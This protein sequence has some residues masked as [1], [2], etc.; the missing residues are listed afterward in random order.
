MSDKIRN[1]RN[2]WIDVETEGR[3]IATGPRKN[4]EST[5]I[6]LSVREK[7]K[8]KAILQI[9]CHQEKEDLLVRIWDYEKLD[10]I[11]RSVHIR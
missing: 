2:F 11:Y 3:K 1:V 9:C 4:N 8:S 10:Y 7:G 6:T 5:F